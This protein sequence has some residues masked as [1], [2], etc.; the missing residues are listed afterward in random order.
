MTIREFN[1]KF[2]KYPL[3]SLH[4]IRKVFPDFDRRRL[5]EWQQK[6]YIVKIANSWYRFAEQEEDEAFLFLISNKIYN[7]SYI[8]LESALSYYGFIPEGV[9]TI[10]A[11]STM[12]TQVFATTKVKFR[13][14][15]IKEPLFWGYTLLS[16]HGTQIK[17]A[18]P[19]KAILDYL[20]LNKNI[21][22]M[23]EF[24]ELR[25][26]LPIIKQQIS[27]TRI[28]QYCKEFHNT[29]LNKQLEFLLNLLK[30]A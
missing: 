14:K 9:F 21:L 7:P 2:S 30:D 17:L 28:K 13:Y 26:N 27:Q 20:Y 29:R 1:S 24:G 11:V 12:K 19:E 15:K 8:S 6:S 3:F 23:D 10:S 16:A 18:L 22:S 25:W 5:V 4:D